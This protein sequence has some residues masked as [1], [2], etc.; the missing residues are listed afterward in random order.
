M[1]HRIAYELTTALNVRNQRGHFFLSVL[2]KKQMQ[3]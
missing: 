2:L 1:L 3:Q